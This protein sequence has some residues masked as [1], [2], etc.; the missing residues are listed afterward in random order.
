MGKKYIVITAPIPSP[1]PMLAIKPTPAVNMAIGEALIYG[2]LHL[3][4]R[5]QLIDLGISF[6][7]RGLLWY[8]LSSTGDPGRWA[9]YV[10]RVEDDEVVMVKL[11]M[12]KARIYNASEEAHDLL[13]INHIGARTYIGMPPEPEAWE[14]NLSHPPQPIVA[15]H[16]EECPVSV[17]WTKLTRYCR[18]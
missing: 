1:I 16:H 4:E 17:H 9:E 14:A 18:V 8:K 7:F 5:Q 12:V 13:P 2:W 10:V 15:H 3:P 11:G 6:T